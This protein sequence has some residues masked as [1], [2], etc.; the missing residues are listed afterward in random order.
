MAGLMISRRQPEFT[1]KSG[2]K[3]LC[4]IIVEGRVLLFQ[5][6]EAF[7]LE[8]ASKLCLGVQQMNPKSS[9]VRMS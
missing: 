5:R 1:E 7:W 2:P 4:R 6:Y 8:R 3:Q 9:T